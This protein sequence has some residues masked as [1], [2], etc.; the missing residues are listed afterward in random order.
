VRRGNEVDEKK[1][2]KM[3]HST[4]EDAKRSEKREVKKILQQRPSTRKPLLEK[5][6]L[7]GEK[8]TGYVGHTQRGGK[9]RSCQGGGETSCSGKK[10]NWTL[11]VSVP[12]E[13]SLQ[14]GMGQFMGMKT[15]T[16]KMTFSGGDRRHDPFK[17]NLEAEGVRRWVQPS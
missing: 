3:R 1:G 15:S 12:Q 4:V 9:Q 11:L 5:I 16:R 8:D 10:A 7:P 13:D 2:V 17:K 14:D 6:Q